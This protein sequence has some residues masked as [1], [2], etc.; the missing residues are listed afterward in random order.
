MDA[1]VVR[2]YAGVQKLLRYN[3]MFHSNTFM[4]AALPLIEWRE[5]IH[6]MAEVGSTMWE[7][8]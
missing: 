8:R 1:I 6:K 2:A 7:V 5:I 4:S 3:E